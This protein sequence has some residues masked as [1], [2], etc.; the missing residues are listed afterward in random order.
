MQQAIKD[1]GGLTSP[2]G[3]QIPIA[4]KAAVAVGLAR[5]FLVGDPKIQVID[6]LAGSLMDDLATAEQM[7][8]RGEVVL[9]PSAISRLGD[10]ARISDWRIDHESERRFGLL[11]G[12]DFE[13]HHISATSSG[14][15]LLSE[16][17]LRPWLLAPV[18]ER[19]KEGQGEFFSELRTVVALFIRF[20]GID[21]DGDD[22]AGKKLDAF[23]TRIQH[24][25]MRYE[26]A[27]LE[28]T[29]G[30]KGSYFYAAFGAP[31]AH[32]DEPTRAAS[33][34]LELRKVADEFDYVQHVQMG[35]SQGE[36]RVGAYGGSTRSA[37]GVQ[38]ND[39]NIAA[40]LM[41]HAEPRQILVTQRIADAISGKF[42]LRE[43]GNI[44]LKGQSKPLP[45]FALLATSPDRKTSGPHE[46][47]TGPMVG[48]DAE[49]A[50]VVERLHA[51]LEGKAS[52][53]MID[54]EAGIGKSRLVA[55]LF[56]QSE[57][58]GIPILL[59]SANAIE[60]S[61]TYY[62]WRTVFQD[63]F[64]LGDLEDAAAV[65][66]RVQSRL[67][68]D[69]AAI[70][71]VPLLNVVLPLGLA[72]TDLTSQMTR[73]VRA[74]NTRE[75]LASLLKAFTD[76]RPFVL[77]IEDA[78]WLDSASWDLLGQVQ[79]TIPRLLI[80]I[81]TRPPLEEDLGT[82]GLQG[83]RIPS[84]LRR[85][86][87]APD[88][89]QI[90]LTTLPPSAIP[91][92]IRHRLMVT[93]LPDAL[94]D[95]VIERAEGHPFFSEEIIY[96]L[97]D[98][99]LIRVEDDRIVLSSEAKDLKDIDLPDTVQGVITN[100]LDHLPATDEMALKVASVIGRI[101]LFRTLR[102]IHP[103]E[104]DKPNLRSSHGQSGETGYYA[105][106]DSRA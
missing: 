33:A 72:D 94:V 105:N 45:S 28:L 25:L 61:T 99:G 6:V 24:V 90:H 62:A 3:R 66:Q 43:L 86:L 53:I 87:A 47:M 60:Q 7:A 100:R 73:D 55:E 37:Y 80:V 64:G 70:D 17:Q 8:T 51:L 34:A 21:Y 106:R 29:V 59:A 22:S 95:L 52:T 38:G 102:D 63:L 49:R 30:D 88:A 19:L 18:Y 2:S 14:H 58:L 82:E 97:R 36:M 83:R 41:T 103:V 4:M 69:Q 56:Q 78:H 77:V 67:S 39:V 26:A 71:R 44:P 89:Q 20:R 10:R 40:R 57:S 31:V 12:L 50:I 84:E 32:E 23:V 65:R 92:L 35:I 79:T 1:L 16:D 42:D 101:F 11:S 81:V 96:S 5:R 46:G 48:R 104:V 15:E 91:G 75:L 27:L 74:D 85:L 98:S 9:A 54:G 68:D 76:A 93:H 13:A